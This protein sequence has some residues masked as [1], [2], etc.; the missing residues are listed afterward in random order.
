MTA[1]DLRI[2]LVSVAV[3]CLLGLAS[4]R[5][6]GLAFDPLAALVTGLL[7]WALGRAAL[8]A[9]ARDNDVLS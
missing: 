3:A 1:R 8:L 6:D 9:W 5:Y 4:A 7:R 2:I